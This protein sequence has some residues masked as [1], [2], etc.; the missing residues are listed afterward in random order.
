MGSLWPVLFYC[1]LVILRHHGQYEGGC[2][3]ALQVE[4]E[5]VEQEELPGVQVHLVHQLLGAGLHTKQAHL[6]DAA[7]RWQEYNKDI[8]KR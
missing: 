6:R 5:P 3:A 8:F 7:W 4:E 1:R 2:L